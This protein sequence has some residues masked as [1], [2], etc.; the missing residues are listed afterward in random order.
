MTQPTVSVGAVPGD[1]TGDKGQVPF[2][3][4]NAG[5]SEL[6][7][8][9][10]YTGVDT[11]V[12]N[13]YV[14]AA[15]LPT[16]TPFVL[17]PGT[18]LLF[19]PVNPSTGPSTLNV[20]N[21][22]NVALVDISGNPFD[23]G[24]LLTSPCLVAYTG[25]VWQ[26]LLTNTPALFESLAATV[27]TPGYMG[28]ILYPQTPAEAA[29]SVTPTA[30]QYPPGDVRRYGNNTVPGTTDM[31]AAINAALAQ[32]K[33]GEANAGGAEVVIPPGIFAFSADLLAPMG[34]PY[35]LGGGAYAVTIRGAGKEQTILKAIAGGSFT[36][37]LYFN[38]GTNYK[39]MGT[40][41]DLTIDGNGLLSDAI[42]LSFAQM[43]RIENVNVRNC[44]GR[45]LYANN[46]LMTRLSKM[47]VT[48][49]GSASVAQVEVDGTL[50]GTTGG[51]TTVVLD[52]LWVQGGNA[53]CVAA[54]NID[55]SF[56]VTV[57]N[58]AYES[59]GIPVQISS[60][61]GGLPNVGCNAVIF[62]GVD[63]EQP[64]T[65]YAAAGFGLTGSSYVTGLEFRNCAGEAPTTIAQCVIFQQC[66]GV[67]FVNNNWLTGGSMT[68][69]Y[70][71]FGASN[72]NTTIEPHPA[73]NNPASTIPWV[74]VNGAQVKSAG[75][76][77]RW[78][79]T[80]SP[81]APRAASVA[82]SG[83]TW[84]VYIDGPAINQGGW[85]NMLVA[86]NSSGTAINS[87][88]GEIGMVIYIQGD[89]FS[90]I[91]FGTSS[92]QFDVISGANFLLL[93]NHLYC[94]RYDN[95]GCWRQ[96]GTA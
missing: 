52:Q 66:N 91:P 26:L 86:G 31:I 62:D 88:P 65:A 6:Y 19:T 28:A 96:L 83:A 2:Q 94:F 95:R 47:Y 78:D 90:T 72:L 68:S 64:T 17:A 48:A 81:G 54:L 46:C 15:V 57:L 16:P 79:Q 8:T 80:M 25:T 67:R 75:P 82:V 73:M 35:L 87:M 7:G 23:G 55:R 85:Y 63:F 9:A 12:A 38:G 49:C 13:A 3:K 20:V 36:H 59:S 34:D 53:G 39:N 76:L 29:A 58:G 27:L 89:G 74:L 1:G 45:G 56:N 4:V 11:G 61:G 50:V 22:G 30:L 33:V 77:V 42:T 92:N 60:K 44:T 21:T 14:V 32:A 18:L 93:A 84:S 70:N 41:R 24:E 69:I 43:G 5:F 51:T 40:L 71:V 10:V 37:G